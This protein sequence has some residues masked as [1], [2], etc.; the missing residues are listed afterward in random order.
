MPIVPV[1]VNTYYPPAQP[2]ARRCLELGEGL[3]A[4]I[5]DA[6]GDAR[7][8]V[9]ASGGLSHFLV[10]PD[11]DNAVLDA[12]AADDRDALARLP[13]PVLCSGTSEVKNWLVAAGAC[14]GLDFEVVDYVPAYR[15]AAGTGTGLCF[16]SW[17]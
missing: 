12:I 5:A 11:F 4:A 3:A 1:F 2:R 17:S 6:P 16:A 13:E 15:T 10:L 14:R 8:G 9:M 7:I